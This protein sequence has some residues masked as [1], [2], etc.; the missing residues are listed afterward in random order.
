MSGKALIGMDT[1]I[2]LRKNIFVAA[3]V[4]FI[5]L[6]AFFLP[7]FSRKVEKA[8]L[9]KLDSLVTSLRQLPTSARPAAFAKYKKS[10]EP[11]VGFS[12]SEAADDRYCG[13]ISSEINYFAN[14]NFNQ[15]DSIQTLR[16]NLNILEAEQGCK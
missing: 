2:T 15:Y 7:F 5:L 13:F 8:K 9:Q 14:P 4:A 11:V 3:F 1:L 16:Q 6:L 12:T 10:N